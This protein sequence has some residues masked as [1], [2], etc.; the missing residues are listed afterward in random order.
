MAAREHG[1]VEGD[2]TPENPENLA[3]LKETSPPENLAPAKETP[4]NSAPTKAI[5]P[6]ENLAP[7]KLPPRPR[8]SHGP[9]CRS[10]RRGHSAARPSI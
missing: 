1:A 2:V 8:S 3:L 5:V 10:P 7:S 4:E 6:L 9:G